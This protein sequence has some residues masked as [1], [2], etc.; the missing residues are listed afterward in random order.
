MIIELEKQINLYV[1][2]NLDNKRNPSFHDDDESNI[3]HVN[4]EKEK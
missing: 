3:N 4:I 2:R 1:E